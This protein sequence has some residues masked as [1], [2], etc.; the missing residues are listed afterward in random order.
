MLLT[1][2]GF[3]VQTGCPTSLSPQAGRGSK[4]LAPLAGI[5]RDLASVF[6]LLSRLLNQDLINKDPNR[7][8]L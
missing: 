3:A 2:G 5:S 7:T 4:S 1:F 6:C 8:L